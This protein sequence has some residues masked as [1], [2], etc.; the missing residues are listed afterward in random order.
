MKISTKGRYSTRAML[1][2]AM[3]SDNG[4]V[5]VRDISKRIAVS[6]RYLELLLTPLRLAGLVKAYRGA[7]GGFALTR[8]PSMIRLSEIIQ[9][10]EGP[11]APVECVDNAETCLRSTSCAAHQVWAEIKEAV[12]V[13]LESTTLQDMVERQRK[14]DACSQ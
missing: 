4:L 13:V 11:T 7:N 14:L 6:E 8:H 9:A 10:L 5:Q 1:D 3:H 12:D 2:L